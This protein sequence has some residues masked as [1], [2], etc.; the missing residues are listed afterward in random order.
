MTRLVRTDRP[1]RRPGPR[2]A[3]A[4]LQPATESADYTRMQAPTWYRSAGGVVF[5]LAIAWF[6]FVRGVEV[7]LLD[8]VDLGI[9]ELGHM[10]TI[11]FGEVAHFLAGSVAQVAAPLALAAYF[12]LSPRREWVGVGVCLAWAGTS[13]YDVSVYIADGP[14]ERLQLIG[15]QHDWAYLLRHFGALESAESIANVVRG[16]GVILAVA[17]ALACL[18]PL[19][20]LLRASP[21]E[22]RAVLRP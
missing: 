17:G 9:H 3:H 11:P 20:A 18:V 6:P 16:S 15:G 10:L 5:V 21:V 2:Y 1:Y 8:Y 12:L 4:R 19:T 7:P 14:Y 22:R 13:A